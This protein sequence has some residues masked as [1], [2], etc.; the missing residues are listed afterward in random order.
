[1][2]QVHGLQIKIEF[3]FCFDKAWMGYCRKCSL[4]KIIPFVPKKPLVVEIVLKLGTFLGHHVVF[5]IILIQTRVDHNTVHWISRSDLQQL[6]CISEWEGCCGSSGSQEFQ[7]LCW[8]PLVG[9][10]KRF[11]N[12][13]LNMRIFW[14]TLFLQKCSTVVTKKYINLNKT[15][16]QTIIFGTPCSYEIMA[17]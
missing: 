7:Q 17:R 9:S 6:L 3:I 15:F 10:G 5:T 16:W 11:F 8:C 14:D 4:Q 13:D 12:G 1:M 2:G